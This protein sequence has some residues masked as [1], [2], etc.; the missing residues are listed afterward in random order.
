MPRSEHSAPATQDQRAAELRGCSFDSGP[1]NC[2]GYELPGRP[3]GSSTRPHRR[4]GA[5]TASASA[6]LRRLGAGAELGAS[7]A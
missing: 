7:A 2:L 4:L 1:C 6:R 5:G 3:C